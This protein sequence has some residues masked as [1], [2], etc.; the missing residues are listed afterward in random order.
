MSVA[1]AF[2]HDVEREFM[3]S[4]VTNPIFV[5]IVFITESFILPIITILTILFEY[6]GIPIR[7]VSILVLGIALVFQLVG[8]YTLLFI[9]LSV[10]VLACLVFSSK[11]KDFN[12]IAWVY[13][14]TSVVLMGLVTL[15]SLSGII[16]DLVFNEV[17]RPNRHSLGMQYPLNYIAHWFSISLVYCYLRN[18]FLK[19][20]EY[21]C[22]FGLLTVS[23][24]VCKAQT[25]SVLFFVLIIGTLIRQVYLFYC[26]RAEK[27][28]SLRL[29]KA[30]DMT[31]RGLQYS[32]IFFAAFMIIASLLY[33]PPISTFLDGFRRLSTF[34]SRFKF[35]RAGLIVYFP[36]LLGVNYPVRTWDG[37]HQVENYFFIDSS[38]IFALLHCGVLLYSIIITSLIVFPRRVYK[39]GTGYGLCILALFACICA[40]E[41]HL[42]DLSFNIFWLMT[43]ADINVRRGK[44]G[45]I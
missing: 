19:A 36:T 21:L 27:Q 32:F 1:D 24:F 18:G 3:M 10:P 8:G 30:N 12:K 44:A 40:M 31:K 29:K 9:N 43:F 6:K 7:V 33:V 15:L 45:V 39:F 26:R 25:S 41:H 42:T 37:T 5:V 28:L 34:T 38:Y 4:V 16:P 23:V 14:V 11:G 17:G 13:F 2:F 20:W 22:L 35:G